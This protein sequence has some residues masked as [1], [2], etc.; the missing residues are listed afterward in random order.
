LL[1]TRDYEQVSM[2]KIAKEAGVSVGAV[3]ARFIDKDAFLYHTI[4][5]AFRSLKDN[6]D[7]S[8]APVRWSRVS[9][10]GIAENIVR[11]VVDGLTSARAAGVVRATLKH[12]TTKPDSLEPFHEYRKLVT[13][14]AVALLAH[15]LDID[16]PARAVRIGLQLVFATI[17]DAIGHKDAVPLKAGSARMTAAL[18]NV[19][20][21]YLGVS[22]KGAWAGNEA[23]D[24]DEPQG[25]APYGTE[26][27]P[28]PPEG[29][30]P[31][32]DPDLRLYKNSISVKPSKSKGPPSPAPSVARQIGG[33]APNVTAIKPPAVPPTPREPP[34]RRPKRRFI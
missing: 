24:D 12:G 17:T 32:I 28:E 15:R 11:H 7:Q 3:Y 14:R 31:I 10:K 23:D 29:N 30:V 13:D 34:R 8:L 21:G 20:M 2:A 25:E 1:V 26:E 22:D 9:T 16:N 5:G 19:F 6:A 18:S 27:P 33:K 4:A